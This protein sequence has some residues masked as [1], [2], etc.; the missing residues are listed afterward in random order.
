MSQ[1]PAIGGQTALSSTI[2]DV[3]VANKFICCV[4]GNFTTEQSSIQSSFFIQRNVRLSFE[5]VVVLD[6]GSGPFS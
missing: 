1:E 5:I 3:S 2:Y 4:S 6:V